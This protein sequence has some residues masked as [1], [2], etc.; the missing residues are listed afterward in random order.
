M[1]ILARRSLTLRGVCR[2]T[3]CF[4]QDWD[5]AQMYFS[6]DVPFLH[7]LISLCALRYLFIPPCFGYGL[8]NLCPLFQCFVLFG[9]LWSTFLDPLFFSY[10]HGV[11]YPALSGADPALSS[12][13]LNRDYYY[14]TDKFTKSERVKFSQCY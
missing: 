11:F 13:V 8:L 14:S 3:P 9:P 4:V 2:I 6:F 10:F 7:V 5:S 12:G 1:N